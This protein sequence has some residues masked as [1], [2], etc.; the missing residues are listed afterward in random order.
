M[1]KNLLRTSIK[2]KLAELSQ[3][4]IFLKSKLILNKIIEGIDINNQNTFLI[5]VS[6]Q[7]EFRTEKLI[8]FLLENKKKVLIP[9]VINE[10]DMIVVDISTNQEF[11][12][13]IDI[14]YIP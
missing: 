3:E 12:G 2:Q 10:S 14:A 5:F 8:D 9:K 6:I 1:Q 11:I 7:K 4:E 13:P